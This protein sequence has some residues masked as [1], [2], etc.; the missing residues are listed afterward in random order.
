MLIYITVPA[1]RIAALRGEDAAKRGGSASNSYGNYMVDHGKPWKNHGIVNF[2]WNPDW[3]IQQTLL[4][5]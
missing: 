1:F 4:E 3:K 2:C 5:K